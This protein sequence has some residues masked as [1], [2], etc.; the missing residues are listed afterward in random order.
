MTKITQDVVNK[1]DFSIP[2]GISYYVYAYRMYYL[3]LIKYLL[4]MSVRQ[5]YIFIDT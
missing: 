1:M 2:L 4:E 5:S 3:F